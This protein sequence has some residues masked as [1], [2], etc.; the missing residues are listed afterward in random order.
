M[1][2]SKSAKYDLETYNI[3]IGW[4]PYTKKK[5]VKVDDV[6]KKYVHIAMA[7]KWVYVPPGYRRSDQYD[8]GNDCT[9]Q[10]SI[11]PKFTQVGEDTCSRGVTFMLVDIMCEVNAD[12]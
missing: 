2:V 11:D 4:H 1:N 10:D 6:S 5:I 12:K 7:G 8:G 9:Y 3:H